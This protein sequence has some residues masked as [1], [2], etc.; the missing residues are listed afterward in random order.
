MKVMGPT[1]FIRAFFF[2]WVFYTYIFFQNIKHSNEGDGSY[3]ERHTNT[4][5][6]SVGVESRVLQTLHELQMKWCQVHHES[7]TIHSRCK[8]YMSQK[9]SHDMYIHESRT[10][11]S[12]HTLH[13]GHTQASTLALGGSVSSNMMTVFVQCSCSVRAVFVQCSC[14]VRAMFVQCIY[15]SVLQYVAVC[16]SVLKCVAACCRVLQRVSSNLLAVC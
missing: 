15:C 7:R 10:I 14:S 16:C 6:Q 5:K 9:W 11:D 8:L 4:T 2:W 3:P 13:M 12:L 1:T